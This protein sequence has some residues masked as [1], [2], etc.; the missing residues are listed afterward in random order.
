MAGSVPMVCMVR[1][2]EQYKSLIDG[3]ET[4]REFLDDILLCRLTA[5][6]DSH[7]VT[8]LDRWLRV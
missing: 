3:G 5:V 2:W 4:K 6:A 1:A 8:T 7:Q